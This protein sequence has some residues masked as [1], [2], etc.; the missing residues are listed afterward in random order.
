[1]GRTTDLEGKPGFALT[2]QA[3]E[4]HIRRAKATSNIC[5]NQGLAVTAA[6]I[7]M[8]LV[9]PHGL[10]EV[11]S[12]CHQ[13]TRKLAEKLTAIPGVER[14]FS[15]HCFHEIALRLPLNA[16]QVIEQLAEQKLLAGVA[17]GK[18]FEEFEDCLTVCAT[19]VRTESEM[20]RYAEALASLLASA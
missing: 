15:G 13:N 8:A 10:E 18:H 7:Y 1:V 16:E 3:R 5:T 17:L 19:E 2:L 11:A 14:A 4:Q 9:G 20:D 12:A 6:T